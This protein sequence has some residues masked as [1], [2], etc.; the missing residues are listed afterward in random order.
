MLF[1]KPR[2]FTRSFVHSPALRNKQI[3]KEPEL[4]ASNYYDA[5]VAKDVYSTQQCTQKLSYSLK[6]LYALKY[7]K[8]KF[9][10]NDV[11]MIPKA[12][13]ETFKSSSLRKQ[14]TKPEVVEDFLHIGTKTNLCPPDLNLEKMMAMDVNERVVI[15][16]QVAEKWENIART[17]L[18][19]VA[20]KLNLQ[21]KPTLTGE[22][23]YD[24]SAALKMG[25]DDEKNPEDVDNVTKI[26]EPYVIP[27]PKLTT[28][29]KLADSSKSSQEDV[30]VP[31]YGTALTKAFYRTYPDMQN[32]LTGIT[33]Y[34]RKLA[35]SWNPNKYFSAMALLCQTSGTGKTKGVFEYGR[36]E[37]WTFF[38]CTRP[39]DSSEFP[40]RSP[41]ADFLLEIAA[42]NASEIQSFLGQKSNTVYGVGS[43]NL[44]H[45]GM[46]SCF[47]VACLDALS[48]SI[49]NTKLSKEAHLKMWIEQ[50]IPSYGSAVENDHVVQF[51]DDIVQDT[52]SIYAG[53][54]SKLC[55]LDHSKKHAGKL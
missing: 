54:L 23:I 28:H 2:V 38:I 5:A 20:S 31:A 55:D 52:R 24:C 14:A 4:A 32:N 44:R 8:A 3:K 9:D 48:E 6:D 1:S 30:A 40:P 13:A 47:M 39:R 25:T 19:E 15:F 22:E 21:L 29:L 16:Q 45:F 34:F 41:V 33:G 46:Y 53:C 17:Q 51:W 18:N 50:Q 35:S 43:E 27:K 36:N 26:M 12:L 10:Y 49:Q 37:A 7:G 11:E 42:I